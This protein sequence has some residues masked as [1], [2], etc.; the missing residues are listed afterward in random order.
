MKEAI[1]LCYL[2][3]DTRLLGKDKIT[4][5]ENRR[6]VFKELP[7][8]E[9][10]V[11]TGTWRTLGRDFVQYCSVDTRPFLYVYDNLRMYKGRVN[12]SIKYRL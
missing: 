8:E 12:S 5:S 9:E 4:E 11:N 7:G 10:R 3:L 1:L 6:G 2:I